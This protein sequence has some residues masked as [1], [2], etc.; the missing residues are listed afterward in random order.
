MFD[1]DEFYMDE[2]TQNRAGHFLKRYKKQWPLPDWKWQQNLLL[3]DT[4]EIN[5]IAVANASM[6]GKVAGQLLQQIRQRKP[7]APR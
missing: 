5:A 4:K 7:A 1:S 6:Q 3:T 2:N